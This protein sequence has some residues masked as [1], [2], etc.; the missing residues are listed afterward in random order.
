[1]IVTADPSGFGAPVGAEVLSVNGRPSRELLSTLTPFAR[2]D[3]HN[4]AKRISL[5]GVTGTERIEYFDVFQGLVFGAPANGLHR[6]VLR[7][8]TGEEMRIELPAFGL[9]ERQAQTKQRDYSGAEP[10]WDWSMRP[11]GVAVLTMPGW[12][13]YESKWDWRT[14]LDDRLNSLGGSRGLIIDLRE[15]EGGRDCGDAILERLTASPIER[16]GA[17][18]RVRF[19]RTP[20]DLDPYLDTWDNG[21]RTLGVGAVAQGDGFYRLAGERADDRILPRGPHLSIKAAA[22]IGPADSSATFQFADKA[23]ASGLVKLFGQTTGGNQRG[24][25]GGCF[26][27]VRLPASGLEFD[28]PL[29]GYFPPGHPP[30]AGIDPDI[31]VQPTAADLAAGYDRTLE[32]AAHWVAA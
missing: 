17:E 8:V 32:T 20:A 24:I 14:W 7:R 25:N 21:F 27:F 13:L 19:Q 4:D 16:P 26:F 12:A 22:L 6:L 9:A 18:L 29:I 1:M 3:G 10:V 31:Q 11:D 2:A 15:N 28:L 23:R 5:L 30:D